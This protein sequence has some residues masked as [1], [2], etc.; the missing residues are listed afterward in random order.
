MNGG[1]I[2]FGALKISL[3]DLAAIEFSPLD[4]EQC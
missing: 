2:N 3:K 1:D 4:L